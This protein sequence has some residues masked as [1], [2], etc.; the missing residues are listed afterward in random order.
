VL[1]QDAPRVEIIH[2]H[3]DADGWLL[4]AALSHT[5]QH[6]PLHGLV[7]ACSGHGTLHHGLEAAVVRAQGSG[8]T[9][10]RSTR[11]ARG[12]VQFREGDALPTGGDLTPAQARVALQLY[13]LDV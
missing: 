5:L 9:V 13:L 4:D 8:V 1:A 11:V 3:T 6:G 10:W 12:G 2:S 7:L